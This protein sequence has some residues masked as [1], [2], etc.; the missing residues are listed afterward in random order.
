[1]PPEPCFF[2]PCISACWSLIPICWKELLKKM[3][4]NLR[5]CRNKKYKII[6]QPTTN[7]EGLCLHPLVESWK[8]YSPNIV[9]DIITLI[10]NP[11]TYATWSLFSFSFSFLSGSFR[12]TFHFLP[13]ITT[14]PF[15]IFTLRNFNPSSTLKICFIT[16]L[17][18]PNQLALRLF[19][20]LETCSR[21]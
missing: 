19:F 7:T 8:I 12:Y 21:T 5:P 15:G 10:I 11:T 9:Q 13:L 17:R 18:N 6:E 4:S 16:S 14:L 3:E 20:K 1:M 2:F